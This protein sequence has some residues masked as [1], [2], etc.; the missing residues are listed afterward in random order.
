MVDLYEKYQAAKAACHE[1]IEAF[2]RNRHGDTG[3]EYTPEMRALFAAR[4]AAYAAWQQEA[5]RAETPT[6]AAWLAV[7]ALASAHGHE[8]TGEI[9][10][11]EV[12]RLAE[13]VLAET[14]SGYEAISA[15]TEARLGGPRRYWPG[16]GPALDHTTGSG[17]L[18]WIFSTP[19]EGVITVS[20]PQGVAVQVRMTWNLWGWEV[21]KV[22]IHPRCRVR[23]LNVANMA[24]N[25]VFRMV[26]RG[27][28]EEEYGNDAVLTVAQ[29][30]AFRASIGAA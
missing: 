22:T 21:T 27:Q 15:L 30:E 13:A 18:E 29:M 8:W 28:T 12:A 26:P 25:V 23:H 9:S 3:W 5:A 10:R 14:P 17:R 11:A 1:A 2:W 24:V 20:R 16:Q 6:Q 7:F 4:D 19:R